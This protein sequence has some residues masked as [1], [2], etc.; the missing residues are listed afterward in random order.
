MAEDGMEEAKEELEKLEPLD[1]PRRKSPARRPDADGI[2][3][4]LP[5]GVIAVIAAFGM[6]YL[7]FQPGQSVPVS[8]YTCA[9]AV[10]C[11]PSLECQSVNTSLSCPAV[12]VSCGSTEMLCSPSMVMHG[13][14]QTVMMNGT[15]G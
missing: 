13:S 12:N 6:A 10:S 7:A 11:A 8:N 14:N 3:K 5:Y 9:P 4:W 2:S 1:S 15:G